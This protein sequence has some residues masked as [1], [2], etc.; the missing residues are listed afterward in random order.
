MYVFGWGR[1]DGGGGGEKM[2]A[3]NL[4]PRLP[5]I[6]QIVNLDVYQP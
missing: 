5:F 4:D 2:F 1:L 3:F 6:K